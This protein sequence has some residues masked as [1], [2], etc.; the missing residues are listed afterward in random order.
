MELVVDDVLGVV[1]ETFLFFTKL[2]NPKTGSIFQFPNFPICHRVAHILFYLFNTHESSFL[3]SNP[4][5]RNNNKNG[6]NGTLF[7]RAKRVRN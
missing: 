6:A 5:E 4:R 7:E 1:D 2:K 3:I